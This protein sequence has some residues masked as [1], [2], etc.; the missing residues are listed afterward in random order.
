MGSVA[1]AVFDAALSGYIYNVTNKNVFSPDV[2][3][4]FADKQ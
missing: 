4:C 1:L 3:M 2:T